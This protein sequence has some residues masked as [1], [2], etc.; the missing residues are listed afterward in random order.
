LA[1]KYMGK[2]SSDPKKYHKAIE[3]W[4]KVQD[5]ETIF[6]FVEYTKVELGQM[7][8]VYLASSDETAAHMKTQDNGAGGTSLWWDW[9]KSKGKHK[10]FP[11]KIPED[12]KFSEN[13]LRKFFLDV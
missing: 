2:G 10:G 1:V 11:N 5:P 13:R 8:H 3:A 4:R 12:W 9:S 6:A 7:P